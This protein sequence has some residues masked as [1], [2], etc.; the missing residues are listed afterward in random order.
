MA[1]K[2]SHIEHLTKK[3]NTTFNHRLQY[4]S[5]LTCDASVIV[6]DPIPGSGWSL[7]RK[8]EAAPYYLS[9]ILPLMIRFSR[10]R[11]GDYPGPVVSITEGLPRRKPQGDWVAVNFE[12]KYDNIGFL[13]IFSN[14]DELLGASVYG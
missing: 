5:Y 10:F 11:R 1:G 9:I 3:N 6:G 8:L 13:G 14:M 2:L 7:R 12:P 4:Y